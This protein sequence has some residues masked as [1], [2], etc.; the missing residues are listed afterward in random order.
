MPVG[1]RM[2]GATTATLAVR[3][4]ACT[5][6]A[7]PSQTPGTLADRYLPSRSCECLSQRLNGQQDDLDRF[8]QAIPQFVRMEPRS[9]RM[10]KFIGHRYDVGS[11]DVSEFGHG[12]ESG[13][14]HFHGQYALGSI[15]SH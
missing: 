7:V 11:S 4:T 6:Q 13:R 14:F 3:V 5:N 8:V 15:V 12:K 1:V 2:P 10:E 9:P